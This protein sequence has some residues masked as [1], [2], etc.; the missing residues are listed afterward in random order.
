MA[1]PWHVG[2]GEWGVLDE[3][4]LGGTATLTRCGDEDTL[5]NMR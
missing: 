3:A 4:A 5:G 2:V 1:E